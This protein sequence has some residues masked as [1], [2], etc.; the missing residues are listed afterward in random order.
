VPVSLSKPTFFK[1]SSLPAE[2]RA[3]I[4]LLAVP[5]QDRLIHSPTFRAIKH[6]PCPV[7]FLVCK[8][9]KA[10]AET[11]YQRLQRYNKGYNLLMGT[12]ISSTGVSGLPIS[13]DH[14]IFLIQDRKWNCWFTGKSN[15]RE[16]WK[17]SRTHGKKPTQACERIE[18]F[19]ASGVR[20]VCVTCLDCTADRGYHE[21]MQGDSLQ[22]LYYGCSNL[23]ERIFYPGTR[24]TLGHDSQEE[25]DWTWKWT[26]RVEEVFHLHHGWNSAKRVFPPLEACRCSLCQPWSRMDREYLRL[27]KDDTPKGSDY[28]T[29]NTLFQR[30]R[31]LWEIGPRPE[32]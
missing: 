24:A 21:A 5:G 1:F 20:R 25:L 22:E 3:M 16:D 32:E 6:A 31:E 15:P 4:W 14:D 9:A 30:S 12:L 11:Q 29:H 26:Y 7:L 19:S 23:C 28:D 2:L 18:R 13:L 10:C 17:A 27:L 8:E